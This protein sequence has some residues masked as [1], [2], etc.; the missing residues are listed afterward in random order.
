MLFPVF[1]R[2]KA[3]AQ[4][5]KCASNMRQLGAAFQMYTGDWYGAYPAPGGLMGNWNYWAQSGNAGLT[6]YVGGR[7][8]GFNTIWTCP[9]MTQWD[10]PY[11]VRSYGMNSFLRRPADV[12]Y[13]SCV[14]IRAP[15]RQDAIPKP[16]RTILLYE[17]IQVTIPL[18]EIKPEYVHRLGVYVYRCGDWTEV[19]GWFTAPAKGMLSA[20]VPMHEASGTNNYLY[21]DGHVKAR[22]PGTLLVRMSPNVTWK[23]AEEWFVDKEKYRYLYH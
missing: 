2:A 7:C 15:I 8:G 3:N 5:V 14:S 23:E 9:L 17:G 16:R 4:Q 12:A 18:P 10:C 13:P 11:P 19:R 22:P 21:C 6:P 20:H 1:V